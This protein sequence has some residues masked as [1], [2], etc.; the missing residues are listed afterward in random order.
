[1]EDESKDK[2]L[3]GEVVE[4]GPSDVPPPASEVA[5][6]ASRMQEEPPIPAPNAVAGR[7][8][9]PV[10]A[11]LLAAVILSLIAVVVAGIFQLTS[12]W[13]VKCPADLPIND[14]APVLWQKMETKDLVGQSIGVP[15]KLLSQTAWKG[16]LPPPE[17]VRPEVGKE[18]K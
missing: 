15:E 14:P 10:A 9:Q 1:M 6:E 12:R 3:E 2:S 18:S 7:R 8:G 13:L 11:G 17:G 5:D 4:A 16:A